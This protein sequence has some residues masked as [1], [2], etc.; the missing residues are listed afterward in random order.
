MERKFQRNKKA[1]CAA[2]FI[3]LGILLQGGLVLASN[4]EITKGYWSTTNA[5]EFYGTTKIVLKVNDPFDVMDTRYRIFAKD[6]ED[7]D[8]SHQIEVDHNVVTSEPGE[9]FINYSVTDSHNNTT[10]LT[11]PVIVS[12]K[13]E[14]KPM[15]ERTLYSL[16]S[17]DN[18]SA[19]GIARGDTHDRQMLGL[20]IQADASIEV[21]K[22]SGGVA[23]FTMLNN[24]SWTEDAKTIGTD[25]QEIKFAHDYVPFVKTL[26]KQT[27]KLVLEIRWEHQDTGVKE[28]NYLLDGD[29]E[30]EFQAKWEADAE[31]YAVV[32]GEA[33]T[34][35]IPYKD[36][37]KLLN[38][39]TKHHKTYAGFFRYW[40][41]VT[42]AF[43]QMLGL[44]YAPEDVVNQNSKSRFFVKA[45]A[46]G[47]GAAYYA[48][49]HVGVN[50]SSVASFFE[51][52]WGG[53]HEFGHGYQGTL[54]KGDLQIG[55][56]SNNIF[57]YYVQQNRE[58]YLYEDN[59]LGKLENIEE[60]YHSKKNEGT[61]FVDLDGS[62]KLYF[63]INMLDSFE[64]AETYGKIATLYRKHVVAGGSMETEDAWALGLYK[65]YGVNILPY[66]EDWG[67]QVADSTRKEIEN[68][69]ES[70]VYAL[71]D[72]VPEEESRKQIQS[73]LGYS[74]NYCLVSNKTLAS[75]PWKGSATVT[76]QIDDPEQC[77]GKFVQLREG[78][79][80]I[81]KQRI[82]SERVVFTNVPIGVYQVKAPSFIGTY[83]R[84][85]THII[86][87]E[88]RTSEETISYQKVFTTNDNDVK[89]QFTG[90]Y[91]N[92]ACEI[93]LKYGEEGPY[94]EF[95]YRPRGLPNS[96]LSEETPYI[97]IKVLN[98]QGVE[99]YRKVVYG[100][101]YFT[102]ENLEKYELP[103]QEGY[104]IQIMSVHGAS[105]VKFLSTLNGDHREA[106][107]LNNSV[108]GEYVVT[109]NGI[110]PANI[111]EGVF[112]EQEHAP[113]MEQYIDA[114]LQST[115][116]EERYNLN[117]YLTQKGIIVRGY[118]TLPEE[119]K[120]Q[121]RTLYEA[122]TK[123]NAP[124]V[125]VK[126][127]DLE[128]SY[129][130]TI[131]L[132]SLISAWD[133]EDGVLDE[134]YYEIQYDYTPT[135]PDKCDIIYK[136]SDSDG[137]VVEAVI[138]VTIR[139]YP[140]V[141]PVQTPTPPVKTPTPPVKTP[142]P[143]V[144][145]PAP[146]PTPSTGISLG[147]V[148]SVSVK[149]ATTTTL[150]LSWKKVS[151]ATGYQVY[152]YNSK[153]KQYTKVATVSATTKKL[154][155]LKAGTSY[156]YKVRAY[157]KANGKTYYGE[158]S[159][160]LSATTKPSQVKVKSASSK[161]KN[162]ITI[163]YQKVS[164]ASGYQVEYST[165]KKFTSKTTTR[166][167]TKATSY[168]ATK[169]K[170]KKTYYVRVRAYKV[171]KSK[172]VYGAWSKVKVVKVK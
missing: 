88:N 91:Y 36:R 119:R 131:E 68:G 16:P 52:N 97:T 49:D 107:Q 69:S 110:R 128:L 39:Y 35:L 11:V 81:A 117:L 27:E 130:Q 126:N 137:N 3:A 80:V 62:G 53:L 142:T 86:V 140:V 60:K 106:Y 44:E 74:L 41:Q 151:G 76:L 71:K 121:Y 50:N 116:E 157:K 93:V 145:T 99:R 143:P 90:N 2:L 63:I 58:I 118:E 109:S 153:S 83:E 51:F 105:R 89:I 78:N 47:A 5:P 124:T 172:K 108:E 123:G 28:L 133:K 40:K 9:Y 158:F 59:W 34:V 18:I 136:V 134:A 149:Q 73:D 154:T 37:K 102:L 129:N 148:G 55:E 164:G 135:I 15:I 82:T 65:Y 138:H 19:M 75:Y 22:T 112:V 87:Q 54:G 170:S 120:E 171:D 152:Q 169:L 12:D 101:G 23:S 30:E 32:E 61:R 14:E 31:S 24:D 43:D 98:E 159:N 42:D 104:R 72:V 29:N 125:E 111:E 95:S 67:L 56:V 21:R 25:W 150:T 70:I 141:P 26:R 33:L 113:R 7:F 147:K 155:K 96:G 84:P 46:H 48:G 156:K 57:G 1:L 161:S 45:N 122:I 160:I 168:K 165:S 8:L 85:S 167:A 38:Y 144:K 64:G 146:T 103:V 6:F 100:K 77:N 92:D 4:E 163:S 20:F 66:F 166:K 114:F 17:V 132:A 13:E 162:Q 115:S 139:N 79:T 127:T 10:T 94:L